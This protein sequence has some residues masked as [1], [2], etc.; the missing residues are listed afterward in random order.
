MARSTLE[1]LLDS[2]KDKEEQPAE[3]LPWLPKRPTS[4][5]RLPSSRVRPSLLFG[6]YKLNRSTGNIS[7]QTSSTTD[8]FHSKE[9]D[10]P[11][12]S[13]A[14]VC[15]LHEKD[16]SHT[17]EMNEPSVNR[18]HVASVLSPSKSDKSH[19]NNAVNQKHVEEGKL[20]KIDMSKDRLNTG[21]TDEEFVLQAMNSIKKQ[22]QS[23][24]LDSM[25]KRKRD[26]HHTWRKVLN[27]LSLIKYYSHCAL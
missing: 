1:L 25:K 20:E 12:V 17:N 10:E 27:L 5:A 15:F 3:E 8:N 21:G 18:N 6:E 26:Y 22:E 2:I 11:T 23:V 24:G 13:L 16:N 9:R 19:S 14:S 7:R 4:R